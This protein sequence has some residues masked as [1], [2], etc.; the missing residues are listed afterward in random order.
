MV[1]GIAIGV[2]RFNRFTR[3]L[4][5]VKCMTFPHI[6][7]MLLPTEYRFTPSEAQ[8][9]TGVSQTQQRDWRRHRHI[10]TDVGG[11]GGFDLQG[12]CTLFILKASNPLGAV[13]R[14]SRMADDMSGPLADHVAAV[15]AGEASTPPDLCGLITGE[16]EATT[17]GNLQAAIDDHVRQHLAT[18]TPQLSSINVIPLQTIATPFAIR[19]RD[20]LKARA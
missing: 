18:D 4:C 20:H 19:V 16:W 14:F 9:L 12:L 5:V 17:H 11:L 3:A 6:R 1:A 8:I 7:P 10:P 13:S 15:V 2:E